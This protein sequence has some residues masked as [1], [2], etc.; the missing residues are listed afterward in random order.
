M[1]TIARLR[2][3]LAAMLINIGALGFLYSQTQFVDVEKHHARL[4]D[5]NEL[6]VLSL[7]ID[8]DV[9]RLNFDQ[10][11][12]YDPIVD[13]QRQRLQ[14]LDQLA[15]LPAGNPLAAEGA[16][17]IDEVGLLERR[18]ERAIDLIKRAHAQLRNS[19]AYLPVLVEE[20]DDRRDSGPAVAD[21][22]AALTKLQDQIAIHSSS[23]TPGSKAA[24]E[25]QIDL[26]LARY[27]PALPDEPGLLDDFDHAIEH[28]RIVTS[29]VGEL[30]A[31]VD[32][33]L[34]LDFHHAAERIYDVF[35]R[36]FAEDQAKS[37]HSIPLF[38]GVQIILL[39][40][41][42]FLFVLLIRSNE[43][44]ADQAGAL[45]VSLVKERQLNGLQRQFVSMVSHE[46]RTPL[47]IIDGYAQRMRR[48]AAS[49]T[50][51]QIE[52]VAQ[53]LR[54]AVR[55]LTE[56]M[57][58]VLSSAHLEEGRIKFEPTGFDLEQLLHEVAEIYRDINAD[59]QI[60]LR[61]GHLPP[62]FFGDPKLLRQVLSNLV[63]NAVKYSPSGAPV[64]IDADRA[65]DT[66]RITI[67]DHGV[68]IPPA[69][70]E[71]LFE[72]F[73]RASSSVGIAGTG[74]GLHLARHLLK[75]HGGRI[76]VE[77][78][79]DVG[80][81]F[82]ALLP[83]RPVPPPQDEIPIPRARPAGRRLDAAADA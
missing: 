31:L 60:D 34:G 77:S 67:K 18:T 24:I 40:H 75:L 37:Q 20:L 69:E 63:S 22:V 72:R 61:I 38:Y 4:A 16:H 54:T 52:Q 44:I 46:F 64:I 28:A 57:E 80:S 56:L 58:S 51:A 42:L 74:I 10:L 83:I 25:R 71:K 23:Q 32:R 50:P 73:F 59:R 35:A 36:I 1:T 49:M 39:L 6:K 43:K 5:I 66:A 9:F 45:E 7:L 81:S 41:V 13:A 62:V 19:K 78:E 76:E 17:L 47:S 21:A 33:Y 11:A 68:G 15:D 53:T 2:S 26:L 3:H 82:T 29:Q 48:K 12:N 65:G 27:R 14:I 70:V 55:R 79:L 8:R 30:R